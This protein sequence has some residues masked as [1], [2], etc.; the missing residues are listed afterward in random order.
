MKK[1]VK[2]KIPAQKARVIE[3]QVFVCDFCEKQSHLT[4]C[5][6]CRRDVCTSCGDYDFGSISDF[7]DRYCPTCYEL[8]FKKYGKQLDKIEKDAW[9]AKEA[10]IKKIK[11]ESCLT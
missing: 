3:K 8:R 7:P 4:S 6:I 10:I 5:S 11:K 2:A 9:K 1:T